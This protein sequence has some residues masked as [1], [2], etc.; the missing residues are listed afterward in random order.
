MSG[1]LNPALLFADVVEKLKTTVQEGR[2]FD[3]AQV[4]LVGLEDIRAAA[5]DNWDMMKERV[6]SNSLNFIQGCLGQADIVIPAGDGFLVIYADQSHRDVAAESLQLQEALNAFYLG[7]EGMERLRS[8]VKG[9]SVGA[10]NMQ[11]VLTF[12]GGDLSEVEEETPLAAAPT[13]KPKLEHECWFAPVWTVAAEAVTTY[14]GTWRYRD[15]RGQHRY[16]YDPGYRADGKL[17]EDETFLDLDLEMLVRAEHAA[18]TALTSGRKCLIGFSV[19]SSTLRRRDLRA[20]YVSR[21]A[22]VPDRLR[23]YLIAR[24]AEVEPGT[25]LITLTE[26]IGALRP[27]T[28]RVVVE[29][30]PTERVLTGLMGVGI[31]SVSLSLPLAGA[32][33][34]DE[35]RRFAE[36]LG[37]WSAVLKKQ[38]I[39]FA[40]DHVIDPVLLELCCRLGVDSVTSEA[41]W[42][43]AK[44]PG[45]VSPFPR[46]SIAA[47]FGR[48]QSA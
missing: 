3:A 22:T 17:N 24:I 47:A 32:A 31:F 7:E 34:A 9:V 27:V 4:K 13:E 8:K 28:A 35:R 1:A 21:L 33:T 39:R 6:R 36:I 41:V 43:L 10:H 42:P 30:H 26:W 38:D 23:K 18:A 5:G 45:A 19:H 16:G 20:A 29:L 48:K 40:V 44:S 14:F 37:R 2:S 11:S 12:D 46:A 15:E 25:P